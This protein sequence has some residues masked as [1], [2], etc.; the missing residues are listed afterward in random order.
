MIYDDIHHVKS[1]YYFSALLSDAIDFILKTDFSFENP[2]TCNIGTEGIYA[3]PQFYTPKK[4]EDRSIECHRKY[5][6]VQLMMMGREYLGYA[7]KN[8]LHF[9]GYDVEHDTE[10]LTGTLTFLPFCKDFFAVLFPQDAHMPGV[11]GQGSTTTVKKIVIKVPI[12][13]W[14]AQH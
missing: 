2:Q 4:K 13:L 8:T 3:I 12:G 6:D 9:S 11:Q 7:N 5:I 14:Q 1:H 10:R